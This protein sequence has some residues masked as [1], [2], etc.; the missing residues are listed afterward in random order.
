LTEKINTT[1]SNFNALVTSDEKVLYYMDKLKFYDAIMRTEKSD[2]NW[3]PPENLNPLIKSDGD[4][5]LTGMSANGNQLFFTYY[6]PYN[7][8]EIYTSEYKEGV[9][10]ELH[11]LNSN[12]NTLFNETHAS[13][14]PDGNLLYFTSDR[15]GGYGGTDIYRSAKNEKGEWDKPVN[16]GPLINSSYNEE[17][18][19]VSPD[20]S[21]LF[22]SSQGHYNMGGFDIF[23]ASKGTDGNWL[24]PVNIGYPLNTTDDDLF[25]FPIDSGRIAYLSRFSPFSAHKDI[26]RFD[27]SSFGKPSRFMINGKI[28]VEGRPEFNA[29]EIIVTIIDKMVHDTLAFR[30]LNDDGSFRQSLPAG[31][32]EVDFNHNNN[33]LLE[34]TLSIPE[35]LPHSNLVLHEK[36]EIPD[37][38]VLKDTLKLGVIRFGFNQNNIDDNYYSLLDVIAGIMMKYPDVRIQVNG[39]ADALGSSQ[40]NL[41]LSMLRANSVKEYL[42]RKIGS[43]DRITV[44][45]FGENNPVALNRNSNGADNPEGRRF[46][47]RAEIVILNAPQSLIIIK[48]N[49]IPVTVM[50][51]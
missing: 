10:S 12:I 38:L 23:Y 14:S 1:V 43:S 31:T 25:F 22:F 7:S 19:F 35:Y 45:A 32:Y 47:R 50:Q 5:Y 27:I 3:L 28:D 4:H 42:D 39:Y 46:N 16:L 17:S 37:M 21:R 9:W 8:G 48:V 29:K 2:N 49:D 33:N 15:K 13:L 24:P 40:Y 30:P 44:D 41:R 11:K 20:G 26:I 6:D 51:K 34:K 18:P 36:V